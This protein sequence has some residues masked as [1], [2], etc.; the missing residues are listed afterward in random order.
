VYRGERVGL[1]RA[2]AIKI[3]HEQLPDELASRERFEREAKLMARLEHPHCVSVIDFGVHEDKPYLVME[4]VRGTPLIDI[5]NKSK[6]LTV[7]RT[8][9]ILRQVLSGLA[10]A[11]ELGIIHRDIKP[12][13]VMVTEKTGLGE[14]VRLLDFG[15]AR[16]IEGGTKITRGIVVGT[17]NYMAPEQ[18]RGGEIDARTDLY[19]CGVMMFEMLVGQKPFSGDDPIQVVRKHINSPPPKLRDVSPDPELESLEL[20]VARALAKSPA[21]RFASASDMAAAIDAAVPR[22]RAATVE[23]SRPNKVATESGWTV[24]PELVHAEPAKPAP[25]RIETQLPVTPSEKARHQSIPAAVPGLPLSK[26]QITIVVAALLATVTVI[27]LVVSRR[28]GAN[29]E[30]KAPDAG[31]VVN[32]ADAEAG[33]PVARATA[34]VTD[35]IAQGDKEAALE[36]A[37]KA[38]HQY[39]QAAPFAA[40]AGRLYFNKLYW[41]EGLKQ[42]RDAVRLDPSYRT[43]PEIIKTVLRGFNTTP[44]LDRQIADFLHD[45]IGSAAVPYLEETAHNHPNSITRD[46]AAAELRRYR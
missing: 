17:P 38:R 6:Q 4:Y 12:A 25:P 22:V 31:T 2:V 3:M 11:H 1:G 15:L 35:L 29:T 39:P 45:E 41:T 8:A 16:L 18:C 44:R 26:K 9:D 28:G 42:L 40:L 34:E 10:H 14:Q 27:A 43:D 13:N 20:I 7:A 36:R 5:I 24:P 46:R 32:A 23:P 19:A 33:D 30:P 37:L 21:D